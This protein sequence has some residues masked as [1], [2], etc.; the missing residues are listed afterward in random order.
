V[1]ELGPCLVFDHLM[2]PAAQPSGGQELAKPSVAVEPGPGLDPSRMVVMLRGMIGEGYLHAG[3]IVLEEVHR[4]IVF[5]AHPRASELAE[6]K[7]ESEGFDETEEE[8]PA[9]VVIEA[10]PAAGEGANGDVV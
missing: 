7:K 8:A 1:E 5:R 3:E 4:R 10:G 6:E 9:A 2:E